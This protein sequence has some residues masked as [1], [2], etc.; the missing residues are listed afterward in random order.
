MSQC[1]VRT[2]SEQRASDHLRAR[3][4]AMARELGVVDLV[5]GELGDLFDR[6][7]ARHVDDAAYRSNWLQPG[8]LSL[9]WSFSEAE[10]DALRI[11][12]QPFDPT[13]TGGERLRCAVKALMPVVE[14]HHG[15][16]LA[17]PLESVMCSALAANSKLNFGAFVGLVHRPRGDDELKMYVECD[18]ED[19][20]LLS[21]DLSNIAGV[22]PHFLSVAVGG[23]AIYRRTYYICRE[24]LHAFDLEGVCAALGMSHRFPALLMTMLEL[25]DGEF[26][27]PPSSVLL[28]IRRHGQESELKVE[29]I[30]GTAMRPDGL[31][32]RIEGLLQPN[33]VVPFRRWVAMI[34]PEEVGTLPVRVVSVKASPMR[35]QR[36]SV[37]A[38]EPWSVC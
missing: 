38:A 24:G 29:L 6:T 3:F 23:G 12:F 13:L 10:P 4:G 20:L 16:H 34:C 11:E 5:H 37:Y 27:L 14:A 25:T 33:T 17:A 1:C 35:P 31:V 2:R 36:L 18:P 15:K 32:G 9:E 30:C 21:G 19:P 26:H 8:A 22:A 7:F 28:G